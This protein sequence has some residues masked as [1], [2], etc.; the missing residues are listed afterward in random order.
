MATGYGGWVGGDDWRAIV[1]ATVENTSETVCTVKVV[2]KLQSQYASGSYWSG[3]ATSNA[4]GGTSSNSQFS[5][6]AGQTVTFKTNTFTVTRTHAAQSITCKATVNGSGAYSGSSSTASVNV[7]VPERRHY[8]ISYN[9]NGGSGSVSSQTKTYGVALTL[10]Q[11]GFT[12]SSKTET[13]ATVTYNYNGSGKSNTTA[14]CKETTSYSFIRWNTKAD[15]SGTSY[16]AGASY[17]ANA[18][19][20]MYAQWATSSSVTALTLP[21]PTRTGYTF[22]GWYTAASGGTKVGNGGASYM[23][24]ANI[25]LYAHWT[26]IT[27]TVSYNANGGS[28]APSSQTKTYGVALTLSST[29][30]TKT[31][32]TFQGWATSSGGSVAYSAGGSYTAN[33][34]ATL[35]AVWKAV[36]YQVTYNANGGS[37]APSSQTKTHGVSL[38]L[39]STKPTKTGYTF[40]GWATSSSATTAGYQPSQAYTA[41]A[42]LALY[43]VWKANTYTVSYNSNG[44]SGTMSSQTRTYGGSAI[45][46]R[47][48]TFTRA[49]TT[50]ATHTV[51]FNYNGSGA[52]STTKTAKNTV[53]YT[54]DRWNTKADGSG[55]YYAAGASYSANA[56]ATMYAQWLPASAT[57]SVTLPT[58]TW[59]GHT[60]DGWYTASSG[61]TRVG[62]GGSTYV[63][64]ANVTLYAHWTANTYTIAYN[65]NKPS[66][67]LGTVGNMPTS[68]TKTY[69][70]ALTL[71]TK[72]PTLTG[73]TFSGWATSSGGSVA[74][75]AGGSYT[76]NA[77]ATLYAKWAIAYTAPTLTKV[78]AK[79]CDSTGAEKDEGAYCISTLTWTNGSGYSLT[80]VIFKAVN[81]SD[82]YSTT[83]NLSAG[84]TSAS[85]VF[86]GGNLDTEK[87]YTVTATL[88]VSRTGDGAAKTVNKVTVLTPSFFTLDF[89]AGG[90]GMAIGQAA[91]ETGLHIAMTTTSE[92]ASIRAK[93]PTID[94]DGVDPSETLYSPLVGFVDKDGETIGYLQVSEDMAGTIATNLYAANE[95][96]GEA[97]HNRISIIVRK[98]GTLGYS[99]SNQS[100]F[101]E[102]INAAG[103]S[104]QSTQNVSFGTGSGNAQVQ[105]ISF[106]VTNSSHALAGKR[107]ALIIRSDGIGLYNSTDSAWLWQ[108]YVQESSPTIS[109]ATATTFKLKK[110]LDTVCLLVDGLKLSAALASGSS[111]SLG[112]NIIPSA[113][114]PEVP[115]RVPILLN[116][117]NPTGAFLIV[118][119]AGS[120]TLYNRS[121]A[122]LSTSVALSA[123]ATWI[124]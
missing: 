55:T 95:V 74:Y 43:A 63:P 44:G 8:T 32:Y 40:Q 11:N 117:A 89:L 45:T 14:S 100:A 33:A 122:S 36:T 90:K 15:G 73:Y 13:V 4:S 59:T 82:T 57:G 23:P 104:D 31:G 68:Q 121:G 108:S 60:F 115:V 25:T 5:C 65:A 52:A 22:A 35:Y 86:G 20:T 61:G 51:T 67:A 46:L 42:A 12:R 113:Y 77:A 34:S 111:V 88:Y 30:P 75:Q 54:F 116:T 24:S 62:G 71:S 101:R 107:L 109:N 39:S 72:V 26:A 29:K 18:A 41:N 6:S 66:A 78:T 19:A 16:N 103:V 93:S 84:A 83:V 114:R 53:S 21:T 27:Y 87:R 69:G 105:L 124:V 49:S 37:G 96:N 2:G 17:T 50:S 120:I 110:Q 7:S 119:S 47:S 92:G 94:R 1:E 28:G 106:N 48:N 91:T 10:R 56:S 9:A 118:G 98:N 123:S 58:P 38:T 85:A 79:R 81:G 3:S 70:V 99:V 97:V 64:T 80:K 76:A 102:A 112:T